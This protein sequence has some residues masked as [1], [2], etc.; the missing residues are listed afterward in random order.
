MKLFYEN[1]IIETYNK[2]V[3]K[4]SVYFNKVNEELTA[5][6]KRSIRFIP[7]AILGF[8]GKLNAE[9]NPQQESQTEVKED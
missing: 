6:D 9:Q 1:E 7:Q 8:L 4:E 5:S 2:Y 3:Y